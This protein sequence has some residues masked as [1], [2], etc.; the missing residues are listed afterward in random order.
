MGS[1]GPAGLIGIQGNKGIRGD[2]IYGDM[3]PQGEAG[4]DGRPAPYGQ[5]GAKGDL[6]WPGPFGSHGTKGSHLLSLQ[7]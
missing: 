5:K 2:I 1:I 3:G 4:K 6:G 7:Y